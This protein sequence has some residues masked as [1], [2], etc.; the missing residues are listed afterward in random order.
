[1]KRLL[2]IV[3]LI[4][5]GGALVFLNQGVRKSAMPD[6]DEDEQAQQAKAAAAQSAPTTPID[7]KAV[8]PAEETVGNPATAQRHIEAGWVYDEGNQRKPE[9]LTVPIQTIHD[10]VNKSGGQVSAEI[11]DLDVPVEDRTPAAQTVTTLG[12]RVDGRSVSTDNLSS[13]P[14]PSNQVIA[15]LSGPPSKP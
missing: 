11:V 9:T 5:L 6:Q 1:M 13:T 15:I 10:L 3:G 12:V 7:P 14:L 2:I 8:L 4:L